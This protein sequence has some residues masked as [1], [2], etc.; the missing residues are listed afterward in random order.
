MT[1]L[2]KLIDVINYDTD[3]DDLIRIQF[4]DGVIVNGYVLDFDEPCR[5]SKDW[6]EPR[7][8]FEEMSSGEISEEYFAEISN[9][10]IITGGA[11]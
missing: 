2:N 4:K 5:N 11:K 6:A 3:S 10:M 7:F 8:V 9:A 1:N